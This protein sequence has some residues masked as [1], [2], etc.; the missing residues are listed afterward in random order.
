MKINIVIVINHIIIN[1]Q[2]Y[3][4]PAVITI[5]TGK[6]NFFFFIVV[7]YRDFSVGNMFYVSMVMFIIAVTLYEHKNQGKHLAPPWL[8]NVRLAAIVSTIP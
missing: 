8:Y 7:K 1:L 5:E 6:I 4:K 2:H 3:S